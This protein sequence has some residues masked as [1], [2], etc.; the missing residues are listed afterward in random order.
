MNVN[1]NFT[2]NR[3]NC[4]IKTAI[5]NQDLN[6]TTS[7][8]RKFNQNRE[9]GITWIQISTIIASSAFHGPKQP[10]EIRNQHHLDQYPH[11]KSF[12][13]ITGTQSSKRIDKIGI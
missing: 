6:S 8:R 11:Q 5:N 12:N 7:S 10:T 9:I 13:S 2:Q 3:E 1:E 4:D